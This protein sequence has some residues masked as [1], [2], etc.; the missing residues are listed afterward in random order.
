GQGLP[1]RSSGISYPLG[2]VAHHEYQEQRGALK[3]GDVV[4]LQTD[5]LQDAMNKGQEFYG[6]ERLLRFLESVPTHSLTSKE[7]RDVILADVRAFVGKAHQYD[8]MTVIV[9]KCLDKINAPEA[10]PKAD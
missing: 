4:L 2:I 6:E 5:G 1:M 10:A 3:P 8:D 9:I 7:I